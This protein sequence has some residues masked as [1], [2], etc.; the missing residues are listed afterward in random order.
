MRQWCAYIYC[1]IYSG[2]NSKF[3]WHYKTWEKL[4]L[5]IIFK[6]KDKTSDNRNLLVN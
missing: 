2:N 1:Q 5:I 3:L 4:E 6:N